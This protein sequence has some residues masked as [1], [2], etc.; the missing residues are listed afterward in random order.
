[1]LRQS[2]VREHVQVRLRYEGLS[3]LYDVVSTVYY[4]ELSREMA[5]KIGAEY[6]SEKVTPRDFDQLAKKAGLGRALV[7]IRV[8]EVAGR[9]IDGLAKVDIA[10]AVAEKVATL[11]GQRAEG[12]RKSFR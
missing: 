8:P 10:H 5:M 1:M 2:P 3:P 12:M 7:R 6:S 4:P 11:P 9:V